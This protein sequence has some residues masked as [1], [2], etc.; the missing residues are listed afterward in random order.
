MIEWRFLL[1]EVKN[2]TFNHDINF[3]GRYKTVLV[4]RQHVCRCD[5]YLCAHRFYNINIVIKGVS[6]QFIY[7][8]FVSE[9]ELVNNLPIFFRKKPSKEMLDKLIKSMRKHLFFRKV[10]AF[11]HLKTKRKSKKGD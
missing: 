9:K 10:R 8:L 7:K 1:K 4:M 3:K 5:N 11:L 2:D 6:M